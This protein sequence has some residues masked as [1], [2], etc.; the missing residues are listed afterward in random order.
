MEHLLNKTWVSVDLET[1]ST[2]QNGVIVSIGAVKFTIKDGLGDEFSVNIDSQSSLEFGL[3]IELESLK[4]WS[5][6]PVH[7]RKAWQ[8]DKEPLPDALTSFNNWLG[9]CSKHL[10][11]ANGSVFDFGLL[12]SSYEATGIS[13]PWAY[14]NEIDL[15]T[16]AIL[17][18]VKLSKGNSHTA[19][20]D[21]KNQANQFISLFK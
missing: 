13:R 11:L 3:N 21:A 4:W 20:G 9:A 1:L 10:F 18:D 7:I 16:I 14:W 2:K 8:I 15:R 19:L 17:L 5:T 6:Q 12:R